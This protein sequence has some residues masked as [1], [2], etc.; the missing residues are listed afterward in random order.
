[1]LL[2]CHLDSWDVGQGAQDDGAGCVLVWHA[3]S[4]LKAQGLT[5]RRTVRVVLYTNEENGLAGGRA[6]AADH[7]D[8]AP[9]PRRRH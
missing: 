6:Y 2:G 7:A 9:Q 4:L 5:P 3:A 1:M 8:G